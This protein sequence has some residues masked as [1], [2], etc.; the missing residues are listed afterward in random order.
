MAQT[1][2]QQTKRCENY[3]KK[4]YNKVHYCIKIPSKKFTNNNLHFL[5]LPHK[6]NFS[7]KSN[8]NT[9]DSHLYIFLYIKGGQKKNAKSFSFVLP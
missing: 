9:N 2:Q 1:K 5:M 4:I 7:T 3:K 8:Q 6:M